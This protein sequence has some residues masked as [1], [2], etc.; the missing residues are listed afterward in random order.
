MSSCQKDVKKSNIWT[1]DE[2]QEEKNNEEASWLHTEL[3]FLFCFIFCC[4]GFHVVFF[5]TTWCPCGNHMVSMRKPCDVHL[6]ATWC[7]H[8]NHV[9]S[10]WKP[11]GNHVVSTWKPHG[12]Y[13]ETTWCPCGNYVVFTWKL[14]GVH[15]DTVVGQ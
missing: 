10:S 14:C 13:M 6:E 3:F 1:M 8:G 11:C 15:M 5:D 9:V 7:P 2:V 12:I 4:V